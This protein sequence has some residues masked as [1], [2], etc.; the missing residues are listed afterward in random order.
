MSPDQEDSSLRASIRTHWSKRKRGREREV[1]V[2]VCVSGE[3]A[4]ATTHAFQLGVKTQSAQRG[5]KKKK[6]CARADPSTHWPEISP[7]S[8]QHLLFSCTAPAGTIPNLFSCL[9]P[10][11]YLF[12]PVIFL[13]F[14]CVLYFCP[15]HLRRAAQS[16]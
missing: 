8:N 4:W 3:G 7:Y 9:F 5:K 16:L 11:V 2:R 13:S 6:K 12:F 15:S 1:C 10:A 14:M